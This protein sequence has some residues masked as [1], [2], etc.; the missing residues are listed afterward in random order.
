MSNLRAFTM[1]KWGIEMTEGT[2]AEWMVR[3]GQAHRRGEVIT[4][5]ET[6][7]I[8]N[9]IEAEYDATVMRLIAEPGS[10]LPVG[11]LLGVFATGP[12]T[13]AEVDAFVAAFRPPDVSTASSSGG[14][15]PPPAGVKPASTA[16]HRPAV[17][18]PVGTAISPGSTARVPDEGSPFRMSI[19][20]F[21]RRRLH[22]PAWRC[23]SYP[24]RL[25]SRSS[26]RRRWP[27]GWPCSTMSTS[28]R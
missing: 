13:T 12:A 17:T 4:L 20:R 19:R 3:E 7:K 23:P 1:P 8:T 27:S 26:T 11:S 28:E 2:V 18:I 25:R 14:G 21:G 5:I 10:T 6:D 22:R 9:E 24:R 16:E 15:G